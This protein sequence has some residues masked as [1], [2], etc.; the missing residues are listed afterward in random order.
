VNGGKWRLRCGRG[1]RSGGSAR[2]LWGTYGLLMGCCGWVG[3]RAAG[4]GFAVLGTAAVL[5]LVEVLEEAAELSAEMAFVALQLEQLQIPEEQA[6]GKL[7]EKPGLGICI[8]VVGAEAALDLAG[9]GTE[10]EVGAVGLVGGDAVLT[11]EREGDLFYQVALRFPHRREAGDDAGAEGGP[12][13]FR[14]EP[15]GHRR[16]GGEAV[17]NGVERR[18][19]LP[20]RGLRA[21]FAFA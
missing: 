15:E 12:G 11:P 6:L 20:F 14:L 16:A 1:S 4:S 2:E 21:A 7:R 13:L 19:G 8:S 3:R 17:G 10:G 18:P 9:G 5:E